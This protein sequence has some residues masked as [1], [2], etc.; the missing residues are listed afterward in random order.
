MATITTTTIVDDIDGSSPAET[1]RFGLD[2]VDYEIDLSEKNAAALRQALESYLAAARRTG[3]RR[4]AKARPATTDRVRNVKIRQWA[5]ASGYQVSDR[6]RLAQD[7][8]D[9]Y[10]A[11]QK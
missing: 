4:G 7:I 2:G 10:D 5:K 1:V 8:I 9:A 6:G 3:G 11:A